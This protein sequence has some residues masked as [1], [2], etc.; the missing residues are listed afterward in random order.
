MSRTQACT[1]GV[2][3]CAVAAGLARC[4][5]RNRQSNAAGA[6]PGGRDHVDNVT[7]VGPLEAVARAATQC[8]ASASSDGPRPSPSS[9]ERTGHAR[10]D[11]AEHHRGDRAAG[12][13]GAWAH[14]CVAFLAGLVQAATLGL[15]RH[16]M[17]APHSAWRF[18]QQPDPRP[19][20][21]RRAGGAA[22]AW[23]AAKDAAAEHE[24]CEH[25]ASKQ[26]RCLWQPWT[27]TS[28]R[29]FCERYARTRARGSAGYLTCLPRS[30]V[31]TLSDA[32]RACAWGVRQ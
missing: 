15:L 14:Q 10:Q 13:R 19:A 6:A 4:S 26:Q 32:P 21:G 30:G 9:V 18:R 17:G 8:S 29:W 22:R 7:H 24:E 3:V 16:V 12:E 1:R 23:S 2:C 31:T 27:Q 11:K 20:R 28:E 5:S 25:P